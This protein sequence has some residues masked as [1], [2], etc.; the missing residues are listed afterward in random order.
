LKARPHRKRRISPEPLNRGVRIVG[1]LGLSICGI[2]FLRALLASQAIP[3]GKTIFLNQ[4]FIEGEYS[5]LNVEDPDTV[6]WHIFSQLSDE[7]YVYPTENYFYFSFYSE[8]RLF[9]GNMRLAPEERD[10]GILHFAYFEYN[11]QPKSPDD[12][13]EKYKEYRPGGGVEVEKI[14]GFV[15]RVASRNKAVTFHLAEL[16]QTVPRGL[17]MR[18]TETF[19]CRTWDES[20]FKFYLLFN[21]APAHFLWVLN[22]EDGIPGT[23]EPVDESLVVDKLSDFAFYVDQAYQRKIL[24]GVNAQN[25][26]RN[27]YYDG[28]FD[29]LADNYIKETDFADFVQQAY[30]YT[31]GRIDR[32]GVFRDV[33]GTRV[34]ITP[35]YAYY[36]REELKDEFRSC[37]NKRDSAFYSCI[38]YDYKQSVPSEKPAR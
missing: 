23:L 29:Q 31:R 11:D 18:R 34:S 3:H 27:N 36:T 37:R 25:I 19:V 12:F 24:V 1:L 33:K 7:V 15:Y 9:M 14:S 4:A 5:K 35:Y 13:Y 8:G 10:Q 26:K 32:Y 2:F 20:G 28:P 38:A 30:P 21:K 6:F 16:D 17:G 22:E